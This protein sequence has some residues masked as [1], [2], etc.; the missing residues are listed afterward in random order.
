[1]KITTCLY[2]ALLIR[3]ASL[4]PDT[5]QTT[6]TGYHGCP[7]NA[8]ASIMAEGFKCSVGSEHY[9]WLGE[10]AYYFTAGISDP[11]QDAVRWCIAES[12]N[13][14]TGGKKYVRYAVLSATIRPQKLL[15]MTT[16]Q[17]KSLLN[18]AR[19]SIIASLSSSFP[20]KKYD[21]SQLIR[22][23]VNRMRFD[24]FLDDLWIKFKRERIDRIFSNR[25]NVRVICVFKPKTVVDISSIT[26]VDKGSIP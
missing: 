1:M 20:R 3:D 19:E 6:Y 7:E 14:D 15:N 22:Y 21:D 2:M 8:V 17:G 23:I 16:D 13:P 26:V 5:S 18:H 4:M 9:K 25:P 11:K 24:A 12:Y 10:G